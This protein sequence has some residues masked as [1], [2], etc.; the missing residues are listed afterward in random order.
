MF[1][2]PSAQILSVPFSDS[3][4]PILSLFCCVLCQV[5]DCPKCPHFLRKLH[6][7]KLKFKVSSGA[8]HGCTTV[9][10]VALFLSSFALL[11]CMRLPC[12]VLAV[13]FNHQDKDQALGRVG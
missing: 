13:A 12:M 1:V 6:S 10:C 5:A 9:T 11:S 3:L 4:V 7:D 2:F 8:E